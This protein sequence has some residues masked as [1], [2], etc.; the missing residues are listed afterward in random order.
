MQ[1]PMMA[2]NPWLILAAVLALGASHTFVYIKGGSAKE[3]AILAEQKRQDEL[4][5]KVQQSTADAIAQIKVKHVT[6]RQE[7]EKQI[8]ERP[9]Y[10]DCSADDRVLELV[11]ESIT[12]NPAIGSGELPATGSDDR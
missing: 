11:N 8:L 12:G 7:L 10:R 2:L 1:N 5:A 3:N 4:I 9:V 6:V